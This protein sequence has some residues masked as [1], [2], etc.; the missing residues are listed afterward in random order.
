[1]N[2]HAPDA[3]GVDEFIHLGIMRED[4]TSIAKAAMVSD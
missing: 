3:R 2:D 1:M 4:E